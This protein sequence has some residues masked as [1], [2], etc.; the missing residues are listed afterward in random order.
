M[1]PSHPGEDNSLTEKE[2]ICAYL[3]TIGITYE[4]WTPAHEIPKA[5]RQQVLATM[6]WRKSD[7][8]KSEGGYVAADVE[9]C[10]CD[11]AGLDAC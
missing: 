5:R 3:G 4:Q 6:L 9:S 10:A 11:H 8:L 2:E 7:R 1:A